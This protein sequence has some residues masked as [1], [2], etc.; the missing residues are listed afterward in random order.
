MP[1]VIHEVKLDF[2]DVLLR[3]KRSS[4]KSRADVEI[5]RKF[6]FLHS[7]VI[8]GDESTSGRGI[9][10]MIRTLFYEQSRSWSI[11]QSG[12][13]GERLGWVGLS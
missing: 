2:K 3:P 13:S 6:T 4:I 1:N 11:I 12:A 9:R 10:D 8:M 5:K 7:K